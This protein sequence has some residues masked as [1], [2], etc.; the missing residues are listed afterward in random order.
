MKRTKSC[1]A[2]LWITSSEANAVYA[3]RSESYDTTSAPVASIC[4][5]KTFSR[6]SAKRLTITGKRSASLPRSDS[7][8]LRSG[9]N[10]LLR[11]RVADGVNARDLKHRVQNVAIEGQLDFERVVVTYENFDAEL[12]QLLLNHFAFD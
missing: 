1:S 3:C 11:M 2:S 4:F 7:A 8:R 12:P 6:S 10:L 5:A 9:R